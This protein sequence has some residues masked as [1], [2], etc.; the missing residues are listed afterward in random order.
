MHCKCTTDKSEVHK[1][2]RWRSSRVQVIHKDSFMDNFMSDCS[3]FGLQLQQGKR[4]WLIHQAILLS[5]L[6]ADQGGDRRCHV[7]M[8]GMCTART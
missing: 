4:G 3:S 1:R 8:T 6:E 5:D 7:H 2:M